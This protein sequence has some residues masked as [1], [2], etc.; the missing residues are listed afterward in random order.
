MAELC[1]Y[2]APGGLKKV[3]EKTKKAVKLCFTA[4][5]VVVVDFL[6]DKMAEENGGMAWV[7][8]V[9]AGFVVDFW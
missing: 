9:C 1:K 2:N 8:R 7:Q 5:F 6:V 3:A 4:R